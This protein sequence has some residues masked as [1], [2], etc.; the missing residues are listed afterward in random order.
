MAL[1]MNQE[2]LKMRGMRMV[3]VVSNNNSKK[4]IDG[5]LPLEREREGLV[6]D[7]IQTLYRSGL[8]LALVHF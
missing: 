2:L 3:H 8:K 5:S 7:M 6:A 1:S 4:D